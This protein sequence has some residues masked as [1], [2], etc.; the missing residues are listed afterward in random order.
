MVR[1]VAQL[2]LNAQACRVVPGC[3][4]PALLIYYGSG[5]A[6]AHITRTLLSPN[7]PRLAIDIAQKRLHLFFN[8]ILD[9]LFVFCKLLVGLFCGPRGW[10][11]QG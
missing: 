5:E 3:A 6:L 8:K 9:L 10:G 7:S 4:P 2:T 1:A 11:E